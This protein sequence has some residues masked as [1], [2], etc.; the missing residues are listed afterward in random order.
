MKNSRRAQRGVAAV[1]AVIVL[2]VFVIVFLGLFYVRDQ[3]IATQQAEQQ[4]RSCAW[5]YSAQDCEGAIPAGCDG[6][7]T[8]ADAP[9][10]APPDLKGKLDEQVSRLKQG[11]NVDGGDLVMGIIGPTV[12]NALEAA[13]GNAVEAKTSRQVSHSALFG[14]GQKTINGQYRLACNLHPT[15]LEDVAK[16]A[17]DKITPW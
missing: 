9:D 3:A 2:P 15:T 5:L 6:V 4:A 1:E 16:D 17:W 12:G 8:R 10:M 7:L 14:P 13:F 11:K